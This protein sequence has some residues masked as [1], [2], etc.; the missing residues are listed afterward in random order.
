MLLAGKSRLVDLGMANGTPFINNAGAGFD[1]QVMATMNS[2]IRFLTGRPAFLLAILMKLPTFRP[3]LLTVSTDGGAPRTLEAMLIAALNGRAFAAG[4]RAAPHAQ[5]DDGALDVMIVRAVSK[6]RLLPLIVRVLYG[7]H[8]GHSA[9]EMCQ[10][11]TITIDAAPPQPVN[12]DGDVRGQTP[13]EIQVIPQA[14]R[15]LV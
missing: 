11:R 10:A 8:L 13:L 9:I 4:L 6:W 14:L 1:A 3:F 2:S 15:V 5:L 12:V 7:T